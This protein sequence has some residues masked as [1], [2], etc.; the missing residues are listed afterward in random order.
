MPKDVKFNIKLNIDG[1]EQI[2]TAS[3]NVKDLANQLGIAKTKGE[4]F[5]DALVIS[6]QITQ[7]ISNLTSGL[8]QL[9]GIMQQYTQ[10][11]AV[12][13]QAEVQVA[14]VM[15]QRMNATDEEIESIK[16]LASAQQALGIIGDEVQLAGVQQIATFLN[17]KSSIEALLPA[18]NDL[19]A[20]QHG[21]NVSSQD[22]VAVANLMGKVM[23]GQTSALKRVGITFTAAQEQIL[24]FGDESQRAATLAQVITDN[25]GHMNSEL[26]KTDAG[27]AKQ[28]SNTIGDIK[29]Q[30]GA[31]FSSV[32]PAIV[33]VAELGLAMNA[34]G[35][36][37][38]AIR[39]VTI[40]IRNLGLVTRLTSAVQAAFTA[41]TTASGTASAGAAVGVTALGVAIRGLMIATG[42]GAVIAGLS[43]AISALADN[44]NSATAEQER[45]AKQLEQTNSVAEAGQRAYTDAAAS[46]KINI[47]RTKD[48]NGT[49]EQEKKLVAELN[50]TYGATMGYFSSVASWYRALVANS[51]AYCRQMVIEAKQRMLANQ[52]AEEET[53][54]EK[55]HD[56]LNNGRYDTKKET[57]VVGAGAYAQVVTEDSE[58]DKANKELNASWHYQKSLEKKMAANA[59]EA[60]SLTMPVKGAPA[61]PTGVTPAKVTGRGGGGNTG[62]T[63]TDKPEPLM[64][65][66]DYYQK[67]LDEL[68]K[69]IYAAADEATAKTLQATYEEKEAQL[70]ELKIRIGLEEPKTEEAKTYMEQLQ[71]RLNEAKKTFD[72]AT[73]VEARVQADAQVQAIQAEINEATYG[74]VSIPAA[75]EPS[76]IQKGSTA[77]L[78]ASYDNAQ[79]RANRVQQDFE[80]GIIGKEEAE[81][82]LADINAQLTEL[83]LNPIEIKLDDTEIKSTF[84]TIRDGYGSIR[85]IGDGIH[86]MTDALKGNG[87]AWQKATATVSA[88]LQVYEGVMSV[89]E[90]MRTFGIISTAA[91]SQA[92]AAKT[93]EAAATTAVTTA[94]V[95]QAAAAPEQILAETAV[96]AAAKLAAQAQLQL[97][98]AGYAAAH[99][100]IPFVG[101]GLAAGFTAAA[102]ALVQAMGAIPLA[103]GGVIS[104]PTLAYV[105]EYSGASHNPEVVAPLD[106]LRSM[107]QPSGGVGGNVRF[108]IEGRKLVGVIGNETQVSGKSGRRNK[109]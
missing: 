62:N 25:V 59:S 93:K 26:A 47:A 9:T 76:Y 46:L 87:D 94:A 109:F 103:S 40:A 41:V 75:V 58:A 90:L 4:A 38:T 85:N 79:G 13:E 80:I 88:A 29:E 49:K 100:N 68:R 42:V 33:A 65:S 3:T 50:S 16:A 105:G 81:R 15:R 73:T 92:A 36:T 43:F 83:G 104:G 107:I 37:V 77:D 67:E 89:I 60:A 8:Q 101:F 102:Q 96:T 23:Q 17:E 44:S 106:K 82:Q 63:G 22:A 74:R 11:A 24:K 34:V 95:A 78:R 21:Y 69:K 91:S 32:E 48:F 27:K 35:T 97:A 39:T 51:Q 56:N 2:V 61:A 53:K 5:R 12:Q 20:Q 28:L 99:A 66:I 18:M 19:L 57:K 55:I 30:V 86:S 14:T 52:I 71:E 84:D 7:G 64:G 1:K 98:A 31:L 108:E 10:A 45:M 6:T 72:N 54:R 70:K